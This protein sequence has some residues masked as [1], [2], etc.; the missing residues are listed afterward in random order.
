MYIILPPELS[1]RSAQILIQYMYSGEATVSNDIL[2]EVLRGG[3]IL[4]IRGLCRN[5]QNIDNP[6]SV[7]PSQQSQSE[8][9]MEITTQKP[10]SEKY[11][12]EPNEILKESPVIVMSSQ[13]QSQQIPPQSIVVKKD[14]AIDPN[15][16]MPSTHYGLVS[17]QIAAAVKKTNFND[18][19]LK[20]TN[21]S[22]KILKQSDR[23]LEDH[24]E[25]G[26]MRDRDLRDSM[27]GRLSSTASESGVLCHTNKFDDKS[28]DMHI[29]EAL[30]FL[31][32]KQEP[33][34]W[35]EYDHNG[36]EKSS[37]LDVQVK[38]ELLY[39]DD[40][41]FKLFFGFGFLNFSLIFLQM[42]SHWI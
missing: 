35:M 2:S 19:R 16:N 30:N 17:L 33:V 21:E 29:P 22:D 28:H 8:K 10:E 32:I 23:I 42:M 27:D 1:R 11:Y 38:P 12:S 24:H 25:R 36:L 9:S 34:E 37:H 3:E 41:G 18:K 7:A 15:E 4:K 14:V 39:A 20:N 40:G 26:V 5:N 31:T 13:Q 6:P